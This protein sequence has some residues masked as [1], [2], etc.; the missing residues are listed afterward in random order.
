M[1]SLE[2]SD[3]RPAKF[4]G[5]SET[6]RISNSCPVTLRADCYIPIKVSEEIHFV[7]CLPRPE[8]P[9]DYMLRL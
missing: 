8:S 2:N 9:V 5:P 1:G 3:P 4:T 7:L 6:E